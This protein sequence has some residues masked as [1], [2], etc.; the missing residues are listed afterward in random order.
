MRANKYLGRAVLPFFVIVGHGRER[1]IEAIDV[2]GLVA[3]IAHDLLVGVVFAAANLA[4]AELA[5]A[6]R[7]VVAVLTVRSAFPLVD[8]SLFQQP[9]VF[10]CLIDPFLC[11]FDS[12]YLLDEMD[13]TV[14]HLSL[15]LFA[16]DERHNDLSVA[17]RCVLHFGNLSIKPEENDIKQKLG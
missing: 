11:Y 10:G 9:D 3:F 12:H 6:A 15:A 5:L 4:A 2:V 1:R 13:G 14:V 7:V 16:H 17:S 8:R